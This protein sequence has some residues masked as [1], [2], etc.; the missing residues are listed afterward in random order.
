MPFSNSIVPQI[1]AEP[2][3]VDLDAITKTSY[4]NMCM[5]SHCTSSPTAPMTSSIPALTSSE[6]V[7]P[8]LCALMPSQMFIKQ[9]QLPEIS[10]L[11]M[12][13]DINPLYIKQVSIM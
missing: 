1:Q 2:A 9:E 5:Q 12:N 8:P 6:A 7:L 10:P 11:Y 13:T 4:R 3:Y